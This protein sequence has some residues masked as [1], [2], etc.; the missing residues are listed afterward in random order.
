M[1]RHAAAVSADSGIK[2]WIQVLNT[3]LQTEKVRTHVLL[4]SSSVNFGILELVKPLITQM[5]PVVVSMSS[6]R[7]TRTRMRTRTAVVSMR[8]RRTLERFAGCAEQPT[9]LSSFKSA[10][11]A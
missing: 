10:G 6:P 5:A 1:K 8:R 9:M 2:Y 4:V 11:V 3:G 7:R